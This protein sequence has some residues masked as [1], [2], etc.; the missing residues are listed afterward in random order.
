MSDRSAEA[1]FDCGQYGF[2]ATFS[3]LG[4][5]YGTRIAGYEAEVSL[6]HLTCTDSREPQI[7]APQF[8]HFASW[9]ASSEGLA[10]GDDGWGHVHSWSVRPG[11]EDQG[12][13]FVRRVRVSVS[14]AGLAKPLKQVAHEAATVAESWWS[15][16]SDWI[17][18]LT[19]QTL[20]TR[21]G[22]RLMHEPA[23][24]VSADDADEAV[25]IV[26]SR[27]H[28]FLPG[29]PGSPLS[30][31][32]V[33]A[34]LTLAGR[35]EPP[36]LEWRLLR[37]ARASLEGQE[38]RRAVLDAAT[39]AELALIRLNE[40]ALATVPKNV[41]EALVARYQ[42]LGLRSQL[43]TKLGGALPDAFQQKLIEPRNDAAH[44]GAHLS[45]AK[46]RD[47]VTAATEITRRALP[48]SEMLPRIPRQ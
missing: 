13:A 47:A 42:M 1:V 28:I 21:G 27:N 45:E 6:P 24:W 36:P 41:N 10:L 30:Q 29:T 7:T 17:E 35:G 44:F 3:S 4:R 46:A 33:Q 37:D 31:D 25:Q 15:V 40:A 22:V 43:F 9:D 11:S 2:L 5:S 23:M 19:A 38:W 8:S 20:R 12:D 34:V 16:A 48:L 18:V 39:A 26:E 14:A 32:Q